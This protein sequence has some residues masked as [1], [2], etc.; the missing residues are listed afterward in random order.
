MTDTISARRWGWWTA[1]G[2]VLVAAL[3]VSIAAVSA[4]A[5]PGRA[6]RDFDVF[7]GQGF[8]HKIDEE[9]VGS[10]VLD[11]SPGDTL[12]HHDPVLDPNTGEQIGDAVTRVRTVENVDGGDVVVLVDCTIRLPDGNIV[13][14]GGDQLSRVQQS[15]TTYA[16]TGGTGAYS[17]ADGTVTVRID[18]VEG[19]DGFRVA[20]GFTRP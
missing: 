3:I 4:A 5:T 12:L 1:I 10:G 13:F 6:Q 14:Y 18:Q 8:L 15:G 7:T 11:L 9:P 17:G 16:I 2:A 20:F 19:Q